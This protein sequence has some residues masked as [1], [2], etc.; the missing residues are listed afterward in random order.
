MIAPAAVGKP[1]DWKVV[2]PRD[3]QREARAKALYESGALRTG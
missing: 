3:R 2:G 1:I